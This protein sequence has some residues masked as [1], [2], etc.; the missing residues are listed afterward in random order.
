MR[1]MKY[2]LAAAL[3]AVTPACDKKKDDVAT[4]KDEAPKA[5][6]P[7][8]DQ[9]K[10]IIE[11][12]PPGFDK[13]MGGRPM[14]GSVMPSYTSKE[15][16]KH[17]VKAQING[18]ISKCNFRLCP[19]E[20]FNAKNLEAN[21][22][23]LPHMMMFSKMHKE[24]KDKIHAFKDAEID[25]H[26]VVTVYVESYVKKGGTT[27]GTRAYHIYWS[28]GTSFVK[29]SGDGFGT[30]R[31]LSPK[32]KWDQVFTKEECKAAAEAYFKHVIKNFAKK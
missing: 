11:D 19:K 8:D 20:G 26:K 31:Y 22:S 5:A 17:K 24:N 21:K 23:K 6:H 10:K 1:S 28:N 25:G 30:A 27:S 13:G 12:A 32:D 2:V 4:P 16:N 14:M 15:A 9:L 29:A 7:T 3:L 18:M